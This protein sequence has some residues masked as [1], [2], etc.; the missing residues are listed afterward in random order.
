M[1]VR[2]DSAARKAIE[3]AMIEA[4]TRRHA[5]LDTGHLLLGLIAAADA[6]AVSALLTLGIEPQRLR[7]ATVRLLEAE[8][9]SGPL[10]LEIAPATDDALLRAYQRSLERD[11]AEVSDVDILFACA[12]D[13]ATT[14]GMALED[15][16]VTA[17]RI[18]ALAPYAGGAAASPSAPAPSP[19]YVSA[20]TAAAFGAPLPAGT[21]MLGN[22]SPATDGGPRRTSAPTRLMF[23]GVPTLPGPSRSGIGYDSHRFEPGGPLVLGGVSIP[24][25]V[26]LVGHSDGD[27]VAHAITD[28]VLGAA[29]A[30][31]IGE[32]FADTDPANRGRDSIEMLR[33]AVGRVRATGFVV[34]QVD[35]TVITEEP[36]LAPYRTA[37][38][39]RLADALGVAPDAVSVKGKTNEGMGWIGRG[40]GLACVAV[41]TL[42]AAP[43]SD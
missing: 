36:K 3:R 9:A 13:A 8:F 27:A 21:T 31:D 28:A 30:G 12:Q 15:V 39:E 29:A 34:Q 25:E 23:G 26:R 6:P 32:M 38:R 24:S 17:A 18:A 22:T 7:D 33:A 43:S 2:F 10:T 4:E 20:V 37:M 35:V 41:A 14:A 42:A 16:G 1:S 40:E 11:A 19:G 5:T